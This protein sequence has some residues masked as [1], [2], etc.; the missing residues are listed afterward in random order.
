MHAC[1]GLCVC[2]CEAV[3]VRMCLWEAVCVCCVRV[4]M[5]EYENKLEHVTQ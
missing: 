4:C 5:L 2:A 3:C 1:V